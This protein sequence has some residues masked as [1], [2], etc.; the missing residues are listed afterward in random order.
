MN[1][2]LLQEVPV[3]DKDS[4]EET[5]LT[6]AIKFEY[7]DVAQILM[8]RGADVNVRGVNGN[9][10]LIRSA[11]EKKENTTQR[12]HPLG[13]EA[14]TEGRYGSQ[15]EGVGRKA[16]DGTEDSP[17]QSRPSPA[18][19]SPAQPR[20]SQR[21]GWGGGVYAGVGTLRWRRSLAGCG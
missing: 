12:L 13:W 17:A 11:F 10:L 14:P 19:P 16:E 6:N 4:K 8:D 21:G 5:P 7:F 18:Q 3:D 15:K 1:F 2:L 9:T 20:P